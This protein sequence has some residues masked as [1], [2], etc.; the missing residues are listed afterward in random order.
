M[1]NSPIL[2]DRQL[3]PVYE[4]PGFDGVIERISSRQPPTGGGPEHASGQPISEA[5]AREKDLWIPTHLPSGFS[6]E[7]AYVQ[8]AP[9]HSGDQDSEWTSPRLVFDNGDGTRLVI[10]AN[11]TEP[12]TYVGEGSIKSVSIG[13]G[14][15]YVIRG[16][17]FFSV[18]RS[19]TVTEKGWDE[20]IALELKF[21]RDDRVITIRSS[22][23][24][25]ISE[26]DLI[27]IAESLPSS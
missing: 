12:H 18:D 27:R 26:E 25:A 14:T 13:E 9:V 10:S 4:P 20:N 3:N 22:P 11:P 8:P 2:I 16:G 7:G 6:I 1:G 21:V 19:G 17:W 23:A 5:Q 15:G 24:A